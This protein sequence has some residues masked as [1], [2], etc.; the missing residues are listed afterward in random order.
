MVLL[1]LMTTI[2]NK[3]EHANLGKTLIGCDNKKS[4]DKIVNKIVK[5]SLHA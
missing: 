1:E 5:L 3:G 4:H 2:A